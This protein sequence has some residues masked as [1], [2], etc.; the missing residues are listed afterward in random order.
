MS[1]RARLEC[2]LLAA[3]PGW[4]QIT[5]GFLE[6]S[7][8]ERE[9]SHLVRAFVRRPNV[10]GSVSAGSSAYGDRTTTRGLVSRQR[11][12]P[13]NRGLNDV[14]RVE[15]VALLKDK[16]MRVLAR[17]WLGESA[18]P[19]RRQE[20]RRASTRLGCEIIIWRIKNSHLQSNGASGSNSPRYCHRSA[21]LHS[22]GRR[23]E[24]P[25][26]RSAVSLDRAPCRFIDGRNSVP[27]PLRLL[28]AS[29]TTRLSGGLWT[30]LPYSR[31]SRHLS[32][33]SI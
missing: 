17:R 22:R 5:G 2:P 10:W 19:G 18:G 33:V 24:D 7:S 11:C 6:I 29:H 8:D 3:R 25:W 16:N 13:S 23:E 12:R 32:R 27:V 26:V 31:V 4:G 28:L 30:D 14:R 9:R 20:A 15:V 21:R 1:L